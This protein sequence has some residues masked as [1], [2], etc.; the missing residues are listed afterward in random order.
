MVEGSFSNYVVEKII[1]FFKLLQ[2][3]NKRWK[4]LILKKNN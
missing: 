1:Y 4:Y 2:I 3:Y